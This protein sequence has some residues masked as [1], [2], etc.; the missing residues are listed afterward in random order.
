MINLGSA[1]FGLSVCSLIYFSHIP[2]W[3]TWE[4]I[5][6]TICFGT[7]CF[8]AGIWFRSLKICNR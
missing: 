2:V 7:S 5:L 4:K 8:N 6:L 1:I 3:D